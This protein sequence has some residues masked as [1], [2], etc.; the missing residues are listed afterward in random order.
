M[1]R[2]AINKEHELRIEVA[3][4]GAATIKLIS[5][6]AELFGVELA[7]HRVYTLSPG[8]KIA[9]YSWYGAEV[10]VGGHV[11][12]CYLSSETHMPLYA[13]LH[14]RLEARREEARKTGAQ[15]PRV[16][17]VGPTDSGKSTLSRILCAYACRVGR[18]PTFVDVDLGQG[19][20][21]V[22]GTLAASPLDRACLS[23]EESSGYTGTVPLVF[24]FGH[25]SPHETTAVYRNYLSRL[26]GAVNRRMAMAGGP[27]GELARCSG[28]VINTMGW[29]E[30]GG[31][32]LLVETIRS[33][34]ADVVCVMGNDRLFAQL[35]DECA[36]M[37]LPAKG[38]PHGEGGTPVQASEGASGRTS[39]TSATPTGPTKAIT[40]VKL[41]R[42][43]G[44]VERAAPTRRDARKGR[45]QEYFYGLDKGPGVP[46]VLSPEIIDVRFEDVTIVRIGGSA[47]E[48][49][50]VPIGK[51]SA[52]ADLRVTPVTPGPGLVNHVLA[53]SYAT[54]S[55]GSASGG[56]KQNLE[57]LPH[58]NVAG[59]VHVRAVDTEAKTLK[60]L[61]PCA[62]GLPG[63]Y[64]I[65]GSIT[66]VET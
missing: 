48:S 51:A 41:P 1:T 23:V 30:G 49:G 56:G 43:G 2:R 65:Q 52:L 28:L 6:S 14:Q 63:R 32:D 55:G 33:F 3:Q 25:P 13:N 9:I 17:I 53:V 26:A 58:T 11:A 24:Y 10:L 62:G 31:Y 54:P 37:R 34:A 8:R 44:V 50:L 7:E 64:L 4:D 12:A 47:S 35:T 21:S 66:W 45:V 42:S 60:L 19:E 18:A 22:P 40:V 16:I 38:G 59:F 57:S 61:A 5:G 29:I 46:P 27:E 20:L 36:K 15:G 39:A